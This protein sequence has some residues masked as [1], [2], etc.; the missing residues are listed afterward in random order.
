MKKAVLLYMLLAGMSLSAAVFS[1]AFEGGLSLNPLSQS[2]WIECGI[3]A[4]F[5]GQ[6]DFSSNITV[7]AGMSLKLGDM[8]F[9]IPVLDKS[10]SIGFEHLSVQY[11]LPLTEFQ[12]VF[13][14][15]SGRDAAFGG[16]VHLQ[17][18]IGA[19]PIQSRFLRSAVGIPEYGIYDINGTGL[20]YVLKFPSPQALGVFAYWNVEEEINY[21]SFDVRFS[22]R[23]GK[24]IFDF[25]GGASSVMGRTR[26]GDNSVPALVTPVGFRAGVTGVFGNTYNTHV[27]VQ[28]AILDFGVKMPAVSLDNFFLFVEP[29][30]VF[31]F[32]Q[33]TLSFFSLP[34]DY[35]ENR[36]L[37]VKPL[38]AAVTM[39]ISNADW[40]DM[41]V[42]ITVSGS[43]MRDL[44]K[45]EPAL[46]IMPFAAIKAG[47]GEFVLNAVFQPLMYNN[48]AELFTFS[49]G[50]KVIIQ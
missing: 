3:D 25:W 4:L 21:L 35:G 28:A 27:F 2:P 42:G 29:R 44:N 33:I 14:A 40:Q 49:A 38:G 5:T 30:L 15:F 47:G 9:F 16:D 10:A 31:G 6:L 8:G 45:L 48:L 7:K 12:H 37:N 18:Y 1:G 19:P 34:S 41:E 50:Y 43:S 11:Y 23:W 26:I 13:S 46:H 32:S 39:V 20:S 17:Q 22:A 36:L 24:G